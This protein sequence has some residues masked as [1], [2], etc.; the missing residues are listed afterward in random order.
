MAKD[1]P[2]AKGRSASKPFFR[3]PKEVLHSSQYAAL[4]AHDVK[5]LN[6]LGAF[7]KGDNNGDLSA[8]WKLMA[9]RGWR[10]KGTLAA[11]IKS[12]TDTGFL[13]VTRQGGRNM[14]TLF[15][16]TFHDI[17]ECAGKHT[18]K[19]QRAPNTWKN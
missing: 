12:L 18:I 1:Y 5:L 19:P 3:W 14:P 10:S 7:Y 4:G 6:D 15:A 16:I 13:M 17:D 8:A 9:K 11:S 2:T